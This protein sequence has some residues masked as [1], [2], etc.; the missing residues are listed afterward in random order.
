MKDRINALVLFA[1]ISVLV[2]SLG[3][4]VCN[5][6][7]GLAGL[8][9]FV[10]LLIYYKKN[11]SID[12]VR[13]TQAIENIY[14]DLDKINQ[15]RMYEMPI[16]M[17]IVDTEGLIYW[18]NQ[19]FGNVFKNDKRA[20]FNK[21][22]IE[23]LNFDLKAAV[24]VE[25]YT[26][27]YEDREYG[28]VTN[29]FSDRIHQ[30]ELVHFF[31]LTEQSRQKQ[32]YRKTSPIFCY[33]VIDNYD[34]INEKLPSHKRSAVLSQVDIKINRWA[35]AIDSVIVEYEN[36]RYL[37]IFERGKICGI[38]DER[39]KI[40]DDVR[41]IE[42]DEKTPVTLSIGIGISEKIL[43]IKESQELSHAALEIALAR[44]GDQAVVRRDDK[45][46][47]YGGKTEATEKRTKVKA[48][49]KAHGL[50]ELIKE[51]D[52]VLLMGHQ[53]PDMDCLGSAIGLLGVCRA[54]DKEARI[55]IREI[56]YSIKSMFEYLLEKG[57]YQEAFITP[58]EVE[59]FKQE[60]TLVII[61]DTQNGNFLEMPELPEQVSKVVVIDH[62]RLS[63]KSIANAIMTYTESYAS[64]TC[65]LVTELI[66]YIDEKE[67]TVDAVE[68]NAL[69]AGICMD[70]K[71][72]TL[73]T[74]VRTFEAAS[75]LKRKGAD[76]IIAKTLLQDDL[77]TYAKKS[78]AV[79]NAKIYFDNIAVS[80]FE[81]NTDSGRLIAAQAADE[82]LNIKGIIAS[83]II[84]KNDDGLNISGRSMGD[85]NV[86]V[87]LEKLGGGGH[88][89][90]A[91]AQLP[92]VTD[93]EIGRELL[94]EAI[95]KY[96]KENE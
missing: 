1:L 25:E 26:F 90:M 41:E 19:A 83:F 74:G 53:N 5:P 72:F 30:F 36:D 64:S 17:A 50:A 67:K 92:N 45:M 62:H 38:Q 34:E 95:E 14:A 47:F 94:I 12:E 58:K 71:M 11:I 22:I 69:L 73:K 63:G 66:Q 10:S 87:I 13:F 85:I 65:E 68:A 32:L 18:Y 40:L 39:F 51:A 75:Y 84:L 55:I 28:V 61:V 60:K 42:N 48:R 35:K 70:T 31:D 29:S 33:V 8:V 3:I 52:N 96:Q 46:L 27:N 59:E 21:N 16:A 24:Q 77:S 81:N 6:I 91:G 86:Q 9:V 82:L 76:T 78:E 43:G 37:M 54:L 89:A 20:L 80:V 15:E 44:G 93:P 23:E 4:L 88:L 49:V 7:L 56:N 57:D 2:L 79:K